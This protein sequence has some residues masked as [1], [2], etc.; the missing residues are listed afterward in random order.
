MEPT[1][2][3][4]DALLCLVELARDPEWTNDEELASSVLD[5]VMAVSPGVLRQSPR[6]K[7]E[8]TETIRELL[9]SDDWQTAFTAAERAAELRITELVPDLAELAAREVDHKVRVVAIES[10]GAMALFNPG[11]A[12]D[13]G[14]LAGHKSVMI[15]DA[16]SV[17]LKQIS[18][19]EKRL[20]PAG[21]DVT[22]RLSA[23]P[24]AKTLWDAYENGKFPTDRARIEYLGMALQI[25]AGELSWE[26]LQPFPWPSTNAVPSE[27]PD[28]PLEGGFEE[29]GMLAHLGY[30]VG[31]SGLP[32]G[33]RRQMLRQVLEAKALPKV[34]SSDYV[35]EWAAPNSSARL[36]KM[37]ESIA[38][39]C[40][41]AKRR[42]NAAMD[43]SIREWESDLAWLKVEFYDNRHTFKWPSTK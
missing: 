16:A 15:A 7:R 17:A 4:I 39:F 8:L 26:D 13:L 18:E 27:E 29:K 2:K 36:R 1:P 19:A 41:N 5:T 21:G 42:K 30:H 3:T 31:K 23:S 9:K 43:E 22:G 28:G 34:N 11:V 12:R 37:A 10:L 40:R 38:A 14:A 20:H 32:S 25:L 35:A 33:K 24:D 6:L